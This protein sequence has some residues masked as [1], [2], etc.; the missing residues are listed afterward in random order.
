[1]MTTT[2][3]TYIS[4]Y[5]LSGGL[6]E[7]VQAYWFDGDSAAAIAHCTSGPEIAECTTE[8]RAGATYYVVTDTA[9][10]TWRYRFDL[11]PAEA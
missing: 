8:E 4:V 3:R 9:G 1:M 2:Q 6:L 5:Q 7:G 10:D 11:T